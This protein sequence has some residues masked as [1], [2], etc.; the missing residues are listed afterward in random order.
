MIDPYD[1]AANFPINNILNHIL[2]TRSL[3]CC[4]AKSII[5]V[6]AGNGKLVLLCPVLDDRLLILDGIGFFFVGNGETDVAHI[7]FWG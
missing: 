4:T 3:K 1:Q 5:N 2:K 6:E 7:L